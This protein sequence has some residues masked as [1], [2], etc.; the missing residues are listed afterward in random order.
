[1][2]RGAPPRPIGLFDTGGARPARRSREQFPYPVGYRIAGD[3]T[4]TGHLAAG[5]RGHLYQVWSARDWC[6]YTCKIVAPD[7]GR[8]RADVA[9]LKREARILRT[10]GHPNI[11]RCY[12]VGSHEGLPFMLLEYLDG[13]SLFDVLES[14]PNRRLEIGDAVRAAIHLG[15]ALYHLHRRGFLHLDLKPAN[16][17]LRDD[18]PVLIDLD[19]ARRVDSDRRPSRRLGTAPYMAPEQARREPLGPGADVWGL[20]ALLYELLT[21]R[22]AFED[23]YAEPME[24]GRPRQFPQADAEMPPA[25]GQFRSDL[26]ESLEHTVMTCLAPDPADRF[27]SMHPLLLALVGELEEPVSLWPAG[28]RAERRQHPRD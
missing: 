22:W 18:V 17:L 14:L 19:T 15:A 16:L 10:V 25:P 5:R 9:A 1:M 21:G 11:V 24:D 8:V 27:T 7:Q 4:V 26:P 2:K 28:I 13:A 12:G 6:A 23:V 20:G 3:L